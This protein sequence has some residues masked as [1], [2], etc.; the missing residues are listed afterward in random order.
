MIQENIKKKKKKNWWFLTFNRQNI[1]HRVKIKETI[2]NS[3][4]GFKMFQ[5]IL[6][7]FRKA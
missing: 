7:L 3:Y 2:T 6:G 4:L 1:S 5:A